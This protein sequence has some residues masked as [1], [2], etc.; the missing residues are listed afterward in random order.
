MSPNDPRLAKARVHI[1]G[2]GRVGTAVALALQASGVGRVSCNDPQALDEEQLHCC[3]F[4]RRSD[5]GRPKVHV[6]QQLFDGRPGFIFEPVVA[7]NESAQVTPWVEQADV[8]VCCANQLPARLHLE[9]TAIALRKP[10]VQASVQ[11]GRRALG[12]MIS[13]WVPDADCCCFGCLFPN[14]NMRFSRDEVLLPTVTT[15][16]GSI[17]AQRIID[18]LI[19]NRTPA[20]ASRPNLLIVDL[21]RYAIEQL[22]VNRRKGCRCCGR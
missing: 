16:I 13:A 18:L 21:A 3:V 12:G 6:L 8:V 10:S 20:I 1:G 19:N 4:S 2:A 11:D 17:A 5:V 7:P 9:R 15:A 14:P 22:S